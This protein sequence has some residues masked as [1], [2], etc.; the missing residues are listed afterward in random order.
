MNITKPYTGTIKNNAL[1]E[2]YS[3]KETSH[4]GVSSP[5]N[6]HKPNTKNKP[7][8]QRIYADCTVFRFMRHRGLEPN[9]CTKNN[10]KKGVSSTSCSSVTQS[11]TLQFNK[12]DR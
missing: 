7:C 2:Q 12:H 11:V 10:E 1:Y 6:F 4:C 3:L 8:N 9:N 5:S